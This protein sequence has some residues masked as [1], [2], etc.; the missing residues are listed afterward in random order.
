MSFPPIGLAIESGIQGA[1]T[2]R[3]GCQFG[4]PLDQ[5]QAVPADVTVTASRYP[6]SSA[7]RAVEQAWAAVGVR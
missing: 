6:D 5:F 1:V 4:S 7:A 2:N 3:F